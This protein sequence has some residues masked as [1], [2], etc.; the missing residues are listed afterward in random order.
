METEQVKKDFIGKKIL[1]IIT[2]DTSDKYIK[3]ELKR[4]CENDYSEIDNAQL[5]LIEGDEAFVFVDFDCDGYRS[6]QWNFIKLKNILDKGSTT[7]IKNINSIIRN[8]EYFNS[9]KSIRSS[10]AD[11]CEGILITT[12]EYVIKMGQ[13]NVNDYYPSNFFDIEECKAFALG[14]AVLLK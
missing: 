8:I 13:D 10:Y 4:I 12:D 11:G 3:N 9:E 6:G 7:E 2:L 1:S 14:D 5:I